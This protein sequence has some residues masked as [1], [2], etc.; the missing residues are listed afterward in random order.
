M[1]VQFPQ[2]NPDFFHQWDDQLIIKVKEVTIIALFPIIKELTKKSTEPAVNK[3][4]FDNDM[5]ELRS[6]T[7]MCQSRHIIL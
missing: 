2:K 7:I 5:S 4:S 3:T 1:S 6:Y